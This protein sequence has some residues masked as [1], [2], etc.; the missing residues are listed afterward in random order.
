VARN[1][2]NRLTVALALELDDTENFLENE[3]IDVS[4]YKTTQ[5]L[6]ELHHDW[7]QPW[8]QLGLR[9]GFRQG[10]DSFG[11]RDDDYFT[12]TDDSAS[13]ARLQFE[14]F[15]IDGRLIYLL[16][17]P[18]RYLDL[19]LYFQHSDDILFDS[20]KLDL[21]SPYTVRGYSSA[22][23]GSNGWYLRND[24]SIT[25]KSNAKSITRTSAGISMAQPSGWWSG[26]RILA[27]ACCGATR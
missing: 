11:A 21:G 25:V 24:V 8:G 5:L 6:L 16:G 12:R 15:S 18:D 19:N 1:Q 7:Y 23:S 17:N 27:G 4:S 20:D 22:L 3:R 2:S 26:M 14:M 10:L 13:E 9:Y